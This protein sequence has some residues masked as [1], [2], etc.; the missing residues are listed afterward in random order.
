MINAKSSMWNGEEFLLVH[1]LGIYREITNAVSVGRRVR[2]RTRRRR[3]S[4]DRFGAKT[5]ESCLLRAGWAKSKYVF[6]K[7][8]VA[9][10]VEYRGR[11]RAACYAFGRIAMAYAQDEIDVGVLI[12]V[13][14][15]RAMRPEAPRKSD[16]LQGGND[17]VSRWDIKRL[18]PPTPLLVLDVAAC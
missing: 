4:T 9:V 2:V 18:I 1:A 13:S 14:A 8:R 17:I 6:S 3:V 5:I 16:E 11:Q 12:L 10:A 7:S 15:Q